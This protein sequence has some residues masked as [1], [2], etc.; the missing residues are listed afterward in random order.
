MYN[1][2]RSNWLF[3]SKR[4]KI[5][6]D[7]I[8]H[9]MLQMGLFRSSRGCGPNKCF[10]GKRLRHPFS[11]LL[12]CFKSQLLWLRLQMAVR[13]FYEHSHWPAFH[14]AEIRFVYLPVQ[15]VG[16][17]F[18]CFCVTLVYRQRSLNEFMVSKKIY[19]LLSLIG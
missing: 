5:N 6:E 9:P 3:D 8:L 11:R 18:L 10:G 19:F 16:H 15:E 1:P 14:N 12:S 2:R 4:G 13:S 17:T 7:S